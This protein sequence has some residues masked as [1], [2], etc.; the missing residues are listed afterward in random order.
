[1]NDIVPHW[2]NEL[3][4]HDYHHIA[5]EIWYNNDDSPLEFKTCD[6]SGEDGSCSISEPGLGFADHGR[7]FGMDVSCSNPDSKHVNLMK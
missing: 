6:A 5:R 1:M 7:Y 3:V 2:P 4:V